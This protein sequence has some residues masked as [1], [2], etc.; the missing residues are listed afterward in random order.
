MN[1]G[2]LADHVRATMNVPLI[3][4]IH[5]IGGETMI[6][7]GIYNNF[8]IHVMKKEFNPNNIIGVQTGGHLIGESKTIELNTENLKTLFTRVLVNNS[9][10]KSMNPNTDVLIHPKKEHRSAFDFKNFKELI[11]IGEESVRSKLPELQKKNK[12]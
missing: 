3:Y 12:T 7:G 1:Y 9:Q 5:Q 8:P 10:Y 2:L 4:P 11:R 6:D